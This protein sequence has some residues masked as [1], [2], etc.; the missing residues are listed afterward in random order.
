MSVSHL[1]VEKGPER[2]REI[3]IPPEG[4]RIGRSSR[5]DITLLDPVMSRFHCRIYW[6]DPHTLAVADLGSSNH[7]LV[8]GHPAQDQPLK[9]GDL[10]TLGDSV[11]KVVRAGGPLSGEAA[12]SIAHPPS[13]PS[14]PLASPVP[15]PPRS[16]LSLIHI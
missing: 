12:A 11:L 16:P 15:A 6:I 1:I 9:I 8:N 5:N 3:T 10:I 13:A 14:S 2:G 4:A 7:T